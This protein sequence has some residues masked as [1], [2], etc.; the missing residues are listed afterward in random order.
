[1]Q[2]HGELGSCAAHSCGDE[3]GLGIVQRRQGWV[4]LYRGCN[5]IA[6]G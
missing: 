2:L 5:Y 3:V 6:V 4:H 1:M